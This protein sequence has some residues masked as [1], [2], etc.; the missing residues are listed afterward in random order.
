MKHMK[1][2][3]MFSKLDNKTKKRNEISKAEILNSLI[4][5]HYRIFNI[6][7]KLILFN[8]QECNLC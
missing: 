4:N 3:L 8:V 7:L 6:K 5:E 2:R 1:R